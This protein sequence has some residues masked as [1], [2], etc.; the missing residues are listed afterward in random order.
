[1]TSPYLLNDPGHAHNIAV[2]YGDSDEDGPVKRVEDDALG[3]ASGIVTSNTTGITVRTNNIL[4]GQLED[5]GQSFDLRQPT[6]AARFIIKA[7]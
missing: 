4:G 2:S 1:V 3:N 5:G 6:I 7:E